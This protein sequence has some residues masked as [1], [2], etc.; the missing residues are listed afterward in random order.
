MLP[1]K[2]D[3]DLKPTLNSLNMRLSKAQKTV[4]TQRTQNYIHNEP[5]RLKIYIT[6]KT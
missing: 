6:G 1:T 2:T 4:E 5:M 3:P